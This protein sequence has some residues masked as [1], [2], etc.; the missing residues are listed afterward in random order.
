MF[1]AGGHSVEDGHRRGVARRV[2]RW[3][4]NAR[5]QLRVWQITSL[6]T[7]SHAIPIA[8]GASSPGCNWRKQAPDRWVR[9]ASRSSTSKN[10]GI[11]L[12][13]L[14][15][16]FDPR[17]AIARVVDGSEFDEFKADAAGLSLVTG[18]PRGTGYPIPHPGQRPAR[19]RGVA[20]GHP[21]HPA[22]QPVAGA[23]C[24]SGQHHQLGEHGQEKS[25]K[26]TIKHGSMTIKT[27]LSNSTVR[28]SHCS[29]A[30][31]TEPATTECAGA[32]ITSAPVSP[33]PFAMADRHIPSTVRVSRGSITPSS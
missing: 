11:V 7:S 29:S 16:P 8:G 25:R 10:Y 20:E 23:R 9:L 17:D 21:V 19:L 32:P 31:R 27:A 2:A 4:R 33:R 6:S 30:R 28:T 5:A 22:G 15:I 24:C 18:G 3:R 13:D 14:R 1:L 12:S 26:A